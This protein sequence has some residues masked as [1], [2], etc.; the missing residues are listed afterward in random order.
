MN[1]SRILALLIL[2]EMLRP[3]SRISG[4]TTTNAMP[5]SPSSSIII[6]PKWI[7]MIMHF[8]MH[9]IALFRLGSRTRCLVYNVLR[10]LTA[11]NSLLASLT[12]VTGVTRKK[13]NA[14]IV[15]SL[16]RRKKSPTIPNHPRIRIRPLHHLQCRNLPLHLPL[17]RPVVTI[18]S[19]SPRRRPK[20][21]PANS[22]KT[23]SSLPKSETAD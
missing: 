1:S 15:Q 14:K 18:L 17:L 20:I 12:L 6:L 11:L 8:A 23:A 3:N 5:N 16:P 4:C 19:I 9:S 21:F 13:S 22:A 2:S 7:G 10:H